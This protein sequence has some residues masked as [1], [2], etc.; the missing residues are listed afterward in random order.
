MT[1]DR[2]PAPRGRPQ[3]GPAARDADERRKNRYHRSVNPILIVE[4]AVGRG[5]VPPGTDPRR[6][7]EAVVAPVWFRAVVQRA[8]VDQRLLDDAVDAAINLVR[9]GADR[10]GRRT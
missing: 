1:R 4:R 6:I 7:I 2:D 9:G 3:H 5:E 8:P 10:P